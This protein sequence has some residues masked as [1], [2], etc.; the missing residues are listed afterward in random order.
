MNALL[1][2]VVLGLLRH[3]ATVG[4]TWLT[5]EGLLTSDQGQAVIGALLTLGAL[6]FSAWDKWKQKDK[7]NGR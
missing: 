7:D 6:A 5:A 1:V 2:Q 4:A 3:L